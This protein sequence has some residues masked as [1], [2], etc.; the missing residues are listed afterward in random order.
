MGFNKAFINLSTVHVIR[1]WLNSL[2]YIYP[3]KS[4]IQLYSF[5]TIRR[6]IK[7]NLLLLIPFLFSS[8][9]LKQC[10]EKIYQNRGNGIL[11]RHK[12]YCLQKL[13][14]N[15]LFKTRLRID[16]IL[17]YFCTG[18]HAFWHDI[19]PFCALCQGF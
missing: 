12:I 5:Y 19:Y 4:E 17:C 11:A 9:A 6:Y 16:F 1:S 18:L 13:I 2:Y 14:S 10:N 8:T 15:T 7:C 3:E